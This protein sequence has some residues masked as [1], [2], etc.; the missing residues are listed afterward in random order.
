MFDKIANNQN[1]YSLA[2][3]FR[4]Q[5]YAFF[6]SLLARLEGPISILDIGGSENYWRTMG[7]I[8]SDQ[9]SITLLNLSVE[10][11]TL[12]NTTSI[13]GDARNL[14]FGDKSFDVTFS[15]SVIEHVG[16][17]A[18]QRKMA[19]EVMRVGKRYFIQTPNKYFPIEPHFL[20]PFF[21]FLPVSARVKLLQ[22]FNLGW[23]PRIPEKAKARAIVEEIQLLEK[24]QFKG[25]F[26]T[27]RL[28]EEK[29]LWMTKSFIAYEGWDE[30]KT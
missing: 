15:N 30:R 24:K 22:R 23:Y 13:V 3:K 21:Q 6:Q 7:G 20:F 2:V 26:P 28:Y 11:I 18:D 1:E 29:I 9:F 14:E 4:K 25:L 12:P 19:E 27:A 5:R 10:N 17:F 8:G 16:G